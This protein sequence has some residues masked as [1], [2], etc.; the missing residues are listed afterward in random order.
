MS[1][2][3]SPCRRV[4]PRRRVF[5][6]VSPCRRVPPC[7]T[8]C[9]SPCCPVSPRVT[10]CRLV[11][12][13]AAP[14]HPCLPSLSVSPCVSPCRPGLSVLLFA[15]GDDIHTLR[16]PGVL[17]RFSLTYLMT[18]LTELLFPHGYLKQ[19]RL[20]QVRASQSCQL[21]LLSIRHLRRTHSPTDLLTY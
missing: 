16:I 11:S 12:L 4:T 9:V 6:R 1:P 17:Q 14:C 21:Y 7:V 13:P 3:V 10:P 8:P 15:V 19:Q 2:H 18:A 5:C 20:S